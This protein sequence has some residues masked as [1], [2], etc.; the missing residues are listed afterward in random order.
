MGECKTKVQ[1]SWAAKPLGPGRFATLVF[2]DVEL[3]EAVKLRLHP[4][5]G[6]A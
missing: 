5:M 4:E 2:K 1:T 6:H 3:S